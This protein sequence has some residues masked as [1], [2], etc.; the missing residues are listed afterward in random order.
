M[1][2]PRAPQAP[3]L[4]AILAR[5]SPL[6]V[7]FRRGPSKHVQLIGWNRSDDSF[8]PG[9]W[10]RGRIYERR[11]DLSPSGKLLVCF[12][13]TH[14]KGDQ[15]ATIISHPPF[16]TAFAEWR[17][18]GAWGGGGLF[19][20]ETTLCLNHLRD[21]VWQNRGYT[22]NVSAESGLAIKLLGEHSGGGEDAPIYQNRRQRDGW[23]LIERG[24]VHDDRAR[25]WRVYP[26]QV[27]EKPGLDGWRLREECFGIMRS[28]KPT[29]QLRICL[30]DRSGDLLA[31]LGEADWADWDGDGVVYA[32]AGRIYRLAA[33][34]SCLAEARLLHDFRVTHPSL[35][36]TPAEAL[37]W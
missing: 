26:R 12:A 10:F 2:Q 27:W 5:A 32:K 11:S 29:Y 31:D 22:K 13:A 28:A 1:T 21:F 23:R 33:G 15:N 30:L 4:F 37:R 8:K 24:V 25:G 19:E 18:S 17:I 34:M 20:D 7:V 6:A 36:E 3:R 9:Q 14:R 35:V 16:L